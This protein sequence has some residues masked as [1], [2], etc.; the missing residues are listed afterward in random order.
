MIQIDQT[1][2]TFSDLGSG[3]PYLLLHGGGGPLTVT[4]FAELLAST[5]ARVI[6]PTHPGFA[7]T[8]RSDTMRTVRDLAALYV[9]LIAKLELRDVT[10]IGNSV[11]GWIAAEMALLDTS[12]SAISAA[13]QPPTELPMTVTS[14]S[15][16]FAIRP[17]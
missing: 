5:P 16:N 2:L 9:G 6:T 1:E 3:R 14:R 15:S 10:V 17:T 4:P 12:R 11:G 7:G 13:I 8:H